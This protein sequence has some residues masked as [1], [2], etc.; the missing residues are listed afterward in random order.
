[1]KKLL[2][3]I[4]LAT[5]FATG[6]AQQLHFMSQYLQHNSM[7]NPAAA[8]MAGRD[9]V[10][11]T[12][13]SMWSTFPGNPKTM[14]VYADVDWKK[15]DAGIGAYIYHDET[16][17]TTRDGIQLAYSYRIRMRNPN[18]RLGLG[19]EFRALQ[20][21]VDKSKLIGALANDPVLA[22]ASSKIKFDAGAGAYITN[23]KISMG[24][25]VQQLIQS[26]LNLA[27]VPNATDEG[28]LYRQY[29]FIGNY[30]WHTGEQIY[31]IPNFLIR[32]NPHAPT[33]WDYGVKLDYKDL[34]WWSLNLR[35]RQF[36]SIQVGFKLLQKIRFSYSYDI[37][38]T[39][40]TEFNDHA[41]SHEIGL[42]F[43]LRK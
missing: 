36:W 37:N 14:M 8:G 25:A 33:E 30:R 19:I 5:C 4:V 22:G 21:R 35:V 3:L 9:F 16:G 31:V 17:P 28:R 43:D 24:A 39:P 6:F 38:V 40:L 18:N 34:L 41:G 27:T 11:A 15:M 20:F 26:R 32:V 23:G 12:Y 2:L 29:N 13:R 10:G 42:Q 7:Y 1:M